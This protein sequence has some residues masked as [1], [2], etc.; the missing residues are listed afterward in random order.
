VGENPHV[1]ASLGLSVAKYRYTCV[2]LSGILA[3]IGGAYLSI[4]QL[5]FFSKGMTNGRGYMALA[6]CVFGRWNPLG[7]TLASFLFGLTDA[8]QL[9][10]QS[11]VK[12]TQFIQMLPYILTVVV[13]SGLVKR[14]IP[15]SALG[16][17]F[18]NQE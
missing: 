9:R 12:Y 1:V 14:A 4:G 6:A 11:S 17:P 16:K 15:P 7:V 8:L 10:L 18:H 5:S 2:I 13:V 3:G